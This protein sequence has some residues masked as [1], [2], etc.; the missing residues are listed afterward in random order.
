M[1]LALLDEDM[2]LAAT[3]S[4]CLIFLSQM[5]T[6]TIREG[7]MAMKQVCWRVCFVRAIVVYLGYLT[8]YLTTVHGMG[9]RRRAWDW[10]L[11][12]ESMA[13]V[14]LLNVE[15]LEYKIPHKVWRIL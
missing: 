4:R 2:E 7:R 10:R 6:F 5:H 12:P 8:K 9:L 13:V 15:K 14:N 1:P 11:G 3:L